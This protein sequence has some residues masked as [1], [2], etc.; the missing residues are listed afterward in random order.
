MAPVPVAGIGAL[1]LGQIGVTAAAVALTL[2]AIAA[3]VEFGSRLYGR[4]V[5]HTGPM[6]KLRQ[7]RR[8]SARSAV[9]T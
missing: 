7:A 1:G 2:A 8:R 5:L 9:T 4:A 3:L 6:L